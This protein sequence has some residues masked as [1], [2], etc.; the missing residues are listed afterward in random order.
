MRTAIVPE[1]ATKL[2]PLSNR[3]GSP[4]GLLPPPP[5]G[6][7]LSFRGGGHFTFLLTNVE[8][9]HLHDLGLTGT[10]TGDF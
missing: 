8:D 6:P 10:W 9:A 3:E 1:S 7:L 5:G 2:E 4:P